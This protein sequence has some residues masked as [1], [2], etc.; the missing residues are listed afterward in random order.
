MIVGVETGFDTQNSEVGIIPGL[1][2]TSV[3]ADYAKGLNEWCRSYNDLIEDVITVGGEICDN[4][5]YLEMSGSAD[6]V[7]IIQWRDVDGY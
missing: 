2:Y 6:N 3:Y 7:W 5:M 4:K 1:A